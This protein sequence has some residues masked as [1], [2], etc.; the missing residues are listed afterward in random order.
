[1]SVVRGIL[2]HGSPNYFTSAEDA[3]SAVLRDGLVVIKHGKPFVAT[4]PASLILSNYSSSIQLILIVFNI[5]Y[6]YLLFC[7]G[8][9]GAPKEKILRW[10]HMEGESRL[11][12]QETP[13]AKEMEAAKKFGHL[14]LSSKARFIRMDTVGAVRLGTDPDPEA[15]SEGVFSRKPNEVPLGTKTL[16]RANLTLT[17]LGHCLSLITDDR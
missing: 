12:W 16:R 8:R 7:T 13:T 14:E 9:S 1:M 4:S 2:A 17:D 5:H 15:K 10:H 6:L 3:L 11:Y